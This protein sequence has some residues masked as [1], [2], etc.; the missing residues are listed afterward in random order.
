MRKTPTNRACFA[1]RT[2]RT[3]EVDQRERELQRRVRGNSLFLISVV[4][5]SPTYNH[6]LLQTILGYRQQSSHG[7]GHTSTVFVNFA[8]RHVYQQRIG[9]FIC[10]GRQSLCL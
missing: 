1:T 2:I 5:T 6:D 9:A 3:I 4:N 7:V 10:M 8:I